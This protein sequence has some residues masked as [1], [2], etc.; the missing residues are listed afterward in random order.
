MKAPFVAIVLF[1]FLLAPAQ[2]QTSPALVS[3]IG[4]AVRDVPLDQAEI[5][6]QLTSE[7]ASF[8]EAVAAADATLARLR[9]IPAPTEGA[10]V[11]FGYDLTQLRQSRWNRGKKLDQQFQAIVRHVPEG[12]VQ[13]VLVR[14][15]DAVIEAEPGMTVEGYETS[16]SDAKRS[17]AER[18]LLGEAV[19][20]ARTT[21]AV[22]AEAAGVRLEST[23]TVLP[24]VALPRID[25]GTSYA[26][27]S[28]VVGASRRTFTAT[29]DASDSVRVPMTVTVTFNATPK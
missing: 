16:L 4:R 22:M 23:R 15:V 29:G 13:Q 8:A 11:T 21:A 24:G 25:G 9:R 27:E 5:T 1:S 20:E 14:L 19:I 3:A 26:M 18:E 2:A 17:V 10:A 7:H 6:F 12:A 28:V